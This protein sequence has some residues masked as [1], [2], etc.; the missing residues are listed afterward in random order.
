MIK[1]MI[2]KFETPQVEGT[3]D[4]LSDENLS[5]LGIS[6]DDITSIT[7]SFDFPGYLYPEQNVASLVHPCAGSACA[8]IFTVDGRN[9]EID[10]IFYYDY[11]IHQTHYDGP[12]WNHETR[13]KTPERSWREKKVNFHQIPK[14]E[15]LTI[16]L[17]EGNKLHG[18]KIVEVPKND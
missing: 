13:F 7:A 15:K 10:E 9:L 17:L 2:I 18:I 3:V 1:K 6:A 8:S 5:K 4:I 12:H 16:S 14:S 11:N